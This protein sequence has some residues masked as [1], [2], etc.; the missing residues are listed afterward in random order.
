MTVRSVGAES[1]AEQ[2]FFSWLNSEYFGDDGARVATR[3]ILGEVS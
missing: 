1:G 3:R 2:S